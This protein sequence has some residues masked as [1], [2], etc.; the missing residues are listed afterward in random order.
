MCARGFI[1]WIMNVG[2]VIY[3]GVAASK[4]YKKGSPNLLQ[5]PENLSRRPSFKSNFYDDA[6]GANMYSSPKA[7][8]LSQ[9]RQNSAFHPDP[10][11]AWDS[12]SPTVGNQQPNDFPQKNPPRIN[13]VVNPITPIPRIGKPVSTPGALVPTPQPDYSP[14]TRRPVKHEP[15]MYEAPTRPVLKNSNAQ[16]QT[17][18]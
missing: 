2:L 7:D 10:I 6:V 12:R 15:Y 8:Y 3:L 11:Y 1:L 18:F 14:P 5:E 13:D 9:G 16:G 4:L 17:Y